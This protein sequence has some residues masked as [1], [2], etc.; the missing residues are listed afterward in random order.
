MKKSIGILLVVL[1]TAS[2]LVGCQNKDKLQET[3]E[4][5]V[6]AKTD[7]S[8]IEEVTIEKGKMNI[9]YPK[10]SN[11]QDEKIAEKWNRIIEDRIANDLE[12]L[13]E[14]DIYNLSYE[15]ASCNEEQV[16]LKLKGNCYYD[17]AEQPYHFIYTY[18]ISL[19]TGE[20]IRLID[21]TDVK[22]LASNV[23]NNTGFQIEA[24]VNEEFIEYIHSAFEN[25]ELLAEML[26][27]FDYCEEGEQPYGYSFYENNKLYLCIEVPH[28][29]G[30]YTIIELN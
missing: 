11:L 22:R 20:S 12:L 29:L 25:E 30:D 3:V 28:D 15:V 26:C 23:Y 27:N 18:N 1:C 21:Q 16:S 5:A 8:I 14:K 2:L 10:L 4:T 6:E 13:S 24:D 19:T 9:K 17:G 7:V